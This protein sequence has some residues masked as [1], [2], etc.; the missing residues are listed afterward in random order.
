[1]LDKIRNHFV[2]TVGRNL[3]ENLV[4][5]KTITAILS[6]LLVGISRS[7]LLTTETD[8]TRALQGLAGAT[9]DIDAAKYPSIQAAID[10][11]PDTGGVVKLPAGVFEISTPLVVTTEDTRIEGAGAATHIKN[12]NQGGKPTLML[13]PKSRDEDSR[14]RIWRL[15]IGNLRLSGDEACGDGILAEGI[16]EIFLI[17]V[18]IDHHGGHGIH[19]IDCYEDPRIA[20][21]IITY[22]KK[23]G[24]YIK[25][26]H[27][28]VVNANQFEENQDALVCVDSFNLCMNG[29]NLDDHLRHGVVIENTY[30]SVLSGNMIEECMGTAIILDRDCYGITLSANVIAHDMGGG[31]DL[32]DAHGCT[33]SANTFTL[34]HHFSVRVSAKSSRNTISANSFCNSH[35]GDKEKRKLVDENN[36]PVRIDIGTGV[37]LEGTNGITLTGNTFSGL[38]GAAVT[39]TGDCSQVLISSNVV[40]DVNRRTQNTD[41]AFV[42][43]KDSTVTITSNLTD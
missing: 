34:L 5:N 9:A 10:A 1:M 2:Y 43:A 27:D 37:I 22:N 38:D 7:L 29:N 32:R 30:G 14:A 35:I 31:I 15:Q 18:S 41:E 19:M 21:C 20:D 28:I 40:T 33:L 4:S 3:E 39:A 26:G 17:G 16:N 23:A 42:V 12:I 13:R 36:D 6:F 25:N 8:A 11:L 24:I